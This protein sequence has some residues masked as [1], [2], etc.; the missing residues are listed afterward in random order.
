MK[1]G[2]RVLAGARR[3]HEKYR[4]YTEITNVIGARRERVGTYMGEQLEIQYTIAIFKEVDGIEM[5][6]LDDGTPYL[7]G[8]GYLAR[9]NQELA[10]NAG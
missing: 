5:G 10:R 8:R 7:S 3:S 1:E 6:V 4:Q 2:R 9:T